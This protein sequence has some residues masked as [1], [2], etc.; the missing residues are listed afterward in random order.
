M[1][2]VTDE[3]GASILIMSAPFV[4][5]AVL[6]KLHLYMFNLSVGRRMGTHTK[7]FPPA[8]VNS[9]MTQTISDMVVL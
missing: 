3:I 8:T 7:I 9:G 1:S 5:S 4:V 2:V 6:V